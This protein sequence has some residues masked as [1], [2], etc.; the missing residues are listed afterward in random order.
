[1]PTAHA[2]HFAAISQLL[3]AIALLHAAGM[4]PAVDRLL[5]AALERV[6]LLPSHAAALSDGAQGPHATLQDVWL[7]AGGALTVQLD[8]S[9]AAFLTLVF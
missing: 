4:E 1:M 9:G 5:I 6:H 3:L 8:R 2:A 7:G